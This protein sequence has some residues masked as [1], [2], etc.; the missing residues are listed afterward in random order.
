[1]ARL[2]SASYFTAVEPAT[3]MLGPRPHRW[4][5]A[6]PRAPVRFFGAMADQE[7]QLTPTPYGN[8]AVTILDDMIRR[9]ANIGASDIHLE[10]K[11]DRMQVRF[12]IDGTM[13]EQP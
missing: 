7:Q 4:T 13:V 9:A 5:L 8:D 6:R 2:T 12:R 11:R 3:D 10:P 1:M